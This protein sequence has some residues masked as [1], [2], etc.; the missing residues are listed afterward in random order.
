MRASTIKIQK[1]Y[2][3][4]LNKKLYLVRLWKEYRKN[5]YEE[6]RIKAKEVGRLGIIGLK[7]RG[8]KFY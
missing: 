1:A 7:V 4:H 8:V 2:R 3:K 5:L 6:E